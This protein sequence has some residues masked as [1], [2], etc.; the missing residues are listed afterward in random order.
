[1]ALKGPMF[2]QHMPNG[3]ND[4]VTSVQPRRLF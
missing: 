3:W 4:N 2:L 1:M